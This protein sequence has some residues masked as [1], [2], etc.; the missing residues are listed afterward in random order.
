MTIFVVDDDPF[1]LQLIEGVLEPLALPLACFQDP[2]AALAALDTLRPQLIITDHLM[3]GLQGVELIARVRAMPAAADVPVLMLTGADEL[4]VRVAAFDVGV[5]DFATR[6]IDPTELLARARA[7]S[8]LGAAQAQ[9]RRLASLLAGEVQVASATLAVQQAHQD[10]LNQQ[11]R[12]AEH[13][14]GIAELASGIAHDI[15]NLLTVISGGAESIAVLRPHDAGVN[16]EISA[17][18]DAVERGA[19]LTR[20]VLAY[21]RRQALSPI[22]FDAADEIERNRVMLA[23]AAGTGAAL[24]LDLPDEP[25]PIGADRT[26]FLTGLI[27]LVA[28]ARDACPRDARIGIRVVARAR[29]AGVPGPAEPMVMI[30]VTDNGTGMTT[31]VAARA[32]DPFFTTK[33]RGEGTGLGLSMVHGF[34]H[35]SGGTLQ[36]LTTPGVG[37][38]VQL[39]FPRTHESAVAPPPPPAALPPGLVAPRVLVVDDDEAVR[40]ALARLLGL[41]GLSVECADGAAAAMRLL[42][43]DHFDAVLSD[44]LMPGDYDGLELARWA[45]RRDLPV[46]L[47][48]GFVGGTLPADLVADPGVRF[49]R[50]P[51]D[52][53]QLIG[54]LQ[55]LIFTAGA[56]A[57]SD[58]ADTEPAS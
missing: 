33:R 14:E 52:S 31:E 24:T 19:T 41:S 8:R 1:N 5:T 37:T 56:H 51:A 22:V 20:Q 2:F 9:M 35:Q 42:T 28:N 13:F 43:E 46:L 39:F 36:L 48:S 27:N 30:E 16:A 54:T 32:A 12:A 7:L 23:H 40:R 53:R 4:A 26:Q 57:D 47:L 55:D 21:S 18:L 6:P 49:L 44:V 34:V 11:L 29:I 50:K 15:N 25:A 58:G 3:P 38:R 17:I 10:R 45:R